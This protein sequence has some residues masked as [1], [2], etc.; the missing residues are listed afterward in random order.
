[1][2][3]QVD[4]PEHVAAR[5]AAAAARLHVT[6]EELLTMSVEEKLAQLEQEFDGAA[7]HVLTKNDELYRRL[8]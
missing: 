5:L 6:P 2:N 8:A 4:L 1:M 3:L 7:E